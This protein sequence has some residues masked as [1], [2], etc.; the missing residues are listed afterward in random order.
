MK[1]LTQF[2]AGIKKKDLAMKWFVPVVLLFFLFSATVVL[3]MSR[4]VYAYDSYIY[5][6]DYFEINSSG[7]K[8][9]INTGNHPIIPVGGDSSIKGVL[10]VYAFA[11]DGKE[12]LIDSGIL[13][14]EL[15]F[16]KNFQ[17]LFNGQVVYADHQT[18]Q[19]YSSWGY[20]ITNNIQNKGIINGVLPVPEIKNSILLVPEIKNSKTL[21]SWRA[22]AKCLA[23]NQKSNPSLDRPTD[24]L[25]EFTYGG[26]RPGQWRGCSVKELRLDSYAI[27]SELPTIEVQPGTHSLTVL[28]ECP[29][30]KADGSFVQQ[31]YQY[32]LPFKAEPW[33]DYSIS[34]EGRKPEVFR[35]RTVNH[36][37]Q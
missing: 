28:L 37:K 21:G 35:Y 16:F 10:S 29:P 13:S 26:Q 6:I 32:G 9:P 33:N 24:F 15:T 2:A 27:P 19:Q 30:G 34:F 22:E 20:Q 4:E 18:I 11:E 31:S 5:V 3:F 17:P 23:R 8:Q 7:K 25:L 36:P 14:G 12:R 1:K